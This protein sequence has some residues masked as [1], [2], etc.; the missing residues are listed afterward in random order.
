MK[1]RILLIEDDPALARLVQRK[2]HKAG[3]EADIARNGEEGLTRYAAGSYGA[4]IVDYSLPGRDGLEVIRQL[5]AGGRLPPTIMV[6]ASGNVN[7]AVAAMK[8]GV[9]DYLVKDI[10]G[11]YLELLPVS[12]ERVLQQHRLAREKRQAEE[13][14]RQEKVFTETSLNALQDLFYVFDAEGRFLRWN[15]SLSGV[16]GYSDEEISSMH[17]L[18]FF[19]EEDRPLVRKAIET[20]FRTGSAS[21][22]ATLLTKAGK[23]IPYEVTGSLLTDS[24]GQPLALCGTGRDVSER[25]RAEEELQKRTRELA[26]RVKELNCVFGISKLLEEGDLTVPEVVRQALVLVPSAWQYAEITCAR[27]VLNGEV[28]QTDNFQETAWNMG[29]AIIVHGQRIGALE[30]C[31]LEERPQ[32]DDGPF[33]KEERRLID[34]IADRLGRY[35]QW[36]TSYC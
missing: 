14:L 15:K 30:V 34:D 1:E 26:E 20:S 5:A 6:T 13:E 22:E 36:Q 4:V 16:T 8:L 17:P 9:G 27:I 29:S 7:V 19:V 31:Y 28:F 24:R 23:R 11:G 10:G 25:K 3:C 33:L 12:I 32:Q 35:V 21:V 2:L 18:E